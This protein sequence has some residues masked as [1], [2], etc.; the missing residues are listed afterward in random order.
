MH[1]IVNIVN[2]QVIFSLIEAFSV[3]AE[4]LYFNE[5]LSVRPFRYELLTQHAGGY[6]RCPRWER[7]DKGATFSSQPSCQSVLSP[8]AFWSA[9]L[10]NDSSFHRPPQNTQ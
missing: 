3:F 2:R 6:S 7:G 8:L 1:I 9:L 4:N 5:I 10:R